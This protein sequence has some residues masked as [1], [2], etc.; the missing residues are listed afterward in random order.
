[1][2]RRVTPLATALIVVSGLSLFAGPLAGSWGN[3]VLINPQASLFTS[4]DSVL[5]VDYSFGGLVGA[6]E[7]EMYFVG[8]FI[9]QGFGMTG[10]IGGF[11]IQADLLFGPS[12]ADFIYDQAIISTTIAGVDIGFYSARLSSAVLGG[13]AAGSAVRL[14]RSFGKVRVVSTSE[15]GARIQD[16][17]FDGITIVHAATGLYKRYVTNP[18]VPVQSGSNCCNGGLTGEKLVVS[19]WSFGCGDDVS[20]TLYMDRAGFEFV[21]FKMTGVQTGI[22]WVVLDLDLTI[23]LQTKSL[24]LTPRL[25]LGKTACVDLYSAF[26]PGPNPASVVGIE[27]YGLGVTCSW[28]GITVKDLSVLNTGRYAITTPRYG[29]A[30]EEIADAVKNGH[31]YYPDYWELLTIEVKGS[32]CC[33]GDLT[34][35]ANTYF[36]QSSSRLFDWGMTHVEASVPVGSLVLR[37]S[38]EASVTGLEHAGIGVTVKW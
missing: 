36:Q 38:V 29:S 35:F 5:H 12:T 37:G 19:G 26:R 9:W 33:E 16:E 13:P 21:G 8:G 15:F 27:S 1:M 18:I 2:T 11:D 22:S 28:G 30:I 6:S 34:F 25:N 31:D 17:D 23:G 14:A 4:I 20:S 10:R 7:S 3:D 32:G 24:T